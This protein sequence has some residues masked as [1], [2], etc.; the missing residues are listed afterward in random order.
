MYVFNLCSLCKE[1][2]AEVWDLSKQVKIV[3]IPLDTYSFCKFSIL[4]QKGSEHISSNTHT[5]THTYI[6]TVLYAHNNTHTLTQL[7][8]Q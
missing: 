5:H 3:D 8:Y 1:S 2:V 6:H 4:E 7:E